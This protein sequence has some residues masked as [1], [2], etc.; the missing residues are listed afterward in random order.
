MVGP[1][2]ENGRNRTT[3]ENNVN[4]CECIKVDDQTVKAT[5]CVGENVGI[6]VVFEI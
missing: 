3:I 1:S 4:V 5:N 2:V 6:Y